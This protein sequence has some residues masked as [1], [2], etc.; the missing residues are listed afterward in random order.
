MQDV[1]VDDDTVPT[2]SSDLPYTNST[3]KPEDFKEDGTTSRAW[4]VFLTVSEADLG[5]KV[6]ID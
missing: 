6:G 4:K 2:W 1:I 3:D 5:I